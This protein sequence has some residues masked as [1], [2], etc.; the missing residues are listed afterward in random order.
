MMRAE[1]PFDLSGPVGAFREQCRES[2]EYQGHGW[3]AA[4]RTDGVWTRHKSLTP[5]W[6]DTVELPARG[7]F[8][9]LH[10]RSAF[11]DQGIEL[12]NNMPF[13]DDGRIFV[14]NGELHGVRLRLPGRIGAEKIFNLIRREDHGDLGEALET[15]DTLLTEKSRYVRAM[16]VGLTDGEKIHASCHF[17]ESPEY[18]TLHYRDDDVHGVSSDPLDASWQPMRNGERLSL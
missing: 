18:F 17:N 6:E 1:I 10:A 5:V 8:L 7:D 14:F 9:V 15:A 16:N 4:W 2:R 13:Y 3:G 12:E 11:R